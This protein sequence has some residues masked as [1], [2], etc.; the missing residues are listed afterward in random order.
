[1][2]NSV[3]ELTLLVISHAS[4]QAFQSGTLSPV[5]MIFQLCADYGKMLGEFRN[6]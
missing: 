1:M 2:L 6:I 3:F 5:A 4:A